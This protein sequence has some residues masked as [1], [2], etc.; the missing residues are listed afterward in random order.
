MDLAW[1]VSLFQ[2][3]SEAHIADKHIGDETLRHRQFSRG[4]DDLCPIAQPRVALRYRTKRPY[5]LSVDTL[6]TIPRRQPYSYQYPPREAH[7]ARHHCLVAAEA[8]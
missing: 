2:I 5:T 6:G 3:R 4:C 1:Q 7:S 8:H